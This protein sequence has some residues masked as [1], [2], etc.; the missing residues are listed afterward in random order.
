MKHKVTTNKMQEENTKLK[1]RIQQIDSQ[2]N[3]K[4]KI[5]DDLLVQ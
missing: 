3:R 2:M 1:A 4:D 5:I